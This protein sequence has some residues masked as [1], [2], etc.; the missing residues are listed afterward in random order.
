M[1]YLSYRDRIFCALIRI[2]Q[3]IGPSPD[4]LDKLGDVTRFL[5]A[6]EVSRQQKNA[7]LELRAERHL[8]LT[9]EAILEQNL[10]LSESDWA[11]FD[12]MVCGATIKGR[13]GQ[14]FEWA[15]VYSHANPVGVC[16]A[17]EAQSAD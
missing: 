3:R 11:D 7:D 5:L 12:W 14:P 13:F 1:S 15:S 10:T 4:H 2:G 9:K 17:D 8:Q 16:T 6:P